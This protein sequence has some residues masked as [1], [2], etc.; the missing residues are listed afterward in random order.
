[1]QHIRDGKILRNDDELH[2][3]EARQQ[4]C[5]RWW[6]NRAFRTGWDIRCRVE[7][8]RRAAGGE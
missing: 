8:E 1:M 4:G 7:Y 3:Y 5:D 6:G 2:G